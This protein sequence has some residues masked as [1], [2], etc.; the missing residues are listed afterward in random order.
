M[1]RLAGCVLAAVLA[2][3][4]TATAQESSVLGRLL[5]PLLLGPGVV[6]RDFTATGRRG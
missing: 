3:A 5:P 4:P 2:L 6:Q 1:R